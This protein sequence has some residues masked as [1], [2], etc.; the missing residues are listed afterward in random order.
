M[1]VDKQPGALSNTLNLEKR[2]S[3]F[4]IKNETIVFVSYVREDYEAAKRLC[5]D[6]KN[7]DLNLKP[8][9][10]TQ[11]HVGQIWEHEIYKAIQASRYFIPLISLR[12]VEKKGFTKKEF[13]Y[14]LKVIKE[15]QERQKIIVIPVRLN[16][17]KIPYSELEKIQYVDL[18]P[19]W[20]EGFEKILQAIKLGD[21]L[22][23]GRQFE[24]KRISIIGKIEKIFKSQF[25]SDP[26][27]IIPDD[28]NRWYTK[29]HN[30]NRLGRYD[31][32][33]KSLDNAI[34]IKPDYANAWISKGYALRCLKRYDEA[35]MCLNRALEINATDAN[36]WSKKGKLLFD[37]KKYNEAIECYDKSLKINPDDADVWISKGK[38]LYK[39]NKYNEAIEC[40]NKA[41]RRNSHDARAWFNKGLSLQSLRRY[42]QAINCYD[43]A[44]KKYPDDIRIW[45]NKGLSL[46]SLGKYDKAIECYNKA[47]VITPT[48]ARIW[49]N[50]GLSLQSL[51]KYDKAIE[52]YDK[53]IEINPDDAKAWYNRA[54]SKVKNH[55]IENGLA[56]LEKAIVID[57]KE[58]IELAEQD[59]DFKSIRK[60]KRFKVL[61]AH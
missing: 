48:D 2:E 14:A 27:K 24:E 6:L 33:I 7:T 43:E 40:Y 23:R 55:D 42:K 61:I 60:D 49:F 28:A 47:I 13:E 41:L 37:L 17:C 36:A 20:K 19:D 26:E 50:K 10:D 5:L 11:I 4:T 3:S 59:N 9:I 39:I 54:C 44:S 52:C 58:F 57:K 46:Q 53:A 34:A 45:F 32:A 30:F 29:G 22:V 21:N 51:G 35:V 1:M 12:A 25:N 16:E 15:T 38:S 56:D 18:F 8:W 31:E